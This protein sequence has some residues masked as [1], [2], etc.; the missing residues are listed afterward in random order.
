MYS[1]NGHA[2]LVPL[3]ILLVVWSAAWKAIALW[4]AGRRADLVWFIVLCVLNT[5][6][7]LDIVYIFA[8]A[9]RKPPAPT[10][11]TAVAS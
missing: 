5:V 1:L 6:G 11:P 8:I 7:I 9:R 10:A 2:G 4:H 3:L